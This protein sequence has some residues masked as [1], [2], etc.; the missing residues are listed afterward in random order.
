MLG[1]IT[2][3]V[4]LSFITSFVISKPVQA[5]AAQA[6]LVADGKVSDIEILKT[7]RTVEVHELSTAVVK[8]SKALEKRANYI[9]N[10]ASQVSHAFKT[11]LTAIQGAIELLKE[12]YATMT[13]QERSQFLS[14]LDTDSKYLESLVNRLLDLARADTKVSFDGKANINEV[15][16]R[17]TERAN[18]K[19][20][21]TK[22]DLTEDIEAACD[23]TVL[24]SILQN[25]IDNSVQHGKPPIS[26][27]AE[28]IMLED[29][30]SKQ[31]QITFQDSGSGISAANIKSIFTPF[32]TTARDQ[33]GTGL[34]L[35]VIKTLLENYNGSIEYKEANSGACFVIKFKLGLDHEKTLFL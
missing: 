30:I 13:E 12:H 33:G 5:V 17:V 10:F 28:L 4:V 27:K 16:Q 29:N 22:L 9:Q 11:P 31:V 1:L 6:K 8:M 32:F 18:N 2:I 25:L 20:I 3:V 23:P 34:G 19:N 24:E 15:L 21:E 7:A 26:I 14:N 35:A